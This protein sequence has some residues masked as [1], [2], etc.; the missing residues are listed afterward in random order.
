MQTNL[1]QGSK[2]K[3]IKKTGEI[4]IATVYSTTIFTIIT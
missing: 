2:C 3:G 1:S 4:T